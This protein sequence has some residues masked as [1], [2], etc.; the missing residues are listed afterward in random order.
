MRWTISSSGALRTYPKL[1]ALASPC[2]LTHTA[3]T[4]VSGGKAGHQD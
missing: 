1:L 3:L 2:A 4:K